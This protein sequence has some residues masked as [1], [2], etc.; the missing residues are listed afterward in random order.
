MPR[1]LFRFVLCLASLCAC[2]ARVAAA[3]APSPARPNVLVLF[4][5]DLRPEL[6]CY[7]QAHMRTPNID[8]L[9]ASGVRFDRAYTAQAVC[10]PSRV[11]FITGL[12]PDAT[13]VH[14]L[15]TRFRETI[16]DVVTLTQLFRSNG[17][18]TIGMGKVYHDEQPAEWNEWI[19]FPDAQEY[20]SDEVM[21]AI[22]KQREEARRLGLKGKELRQMAKGPAYEIA[23]DAAAGRLHDSLMTD[24]AV[25]EIRKRRA[26]PFFMAVGFKRPHLP[27]VA[28]RR[29]WDMY[30]AAD[31][32][33]PANYRLGAPTAPP[34]AL[35]DWGE[36]RAY[37]GIPGSGPVSDAQ[38]VD[39]IR[40]YR[41]SVSYADEQVGRILA[42]LRESGR[43]RDTIVVLWGD[44]GWKLGDHGAWCKH[45]N[46]ETDVRV[47][48]IVRAPGVSRPGASAAAV[49]TIDVYPT[50]CDLAGLD[51]PAR[52]EG[53]SLRPLLAGDTPG[54]WRQAARSQYK[55]SRKSGGDITGYTMVSGDHRY[56][57]WR[58]VLSGD[59]VAAELY[60]HRSDPAED[61]NL[62]QIPEH[63]ALRQRLA[64]E[65]AAARR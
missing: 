32:A 7:G 49:E 20:L 12:R 34:V 27:F 36:L 50:L 9:A 57:E 8:S 17:Y 55:R 58:N 18:H 65:L 53:R 62:A 2:R 23:P 39:L 10:L 1:N 54:D 24:R 52:L 11:S 37:L 41:A 31:T 4:M 59:L 45:T 3:D 64:A 16:P 61:R 63:A 56:T 13:G 28:P 46:F 14:D 30:P 29:F 33:S 35:V 38:A 21:E 19:T 15:K 42:A 48:L 40:G 25:E 44:H 47:P 43:D 26:E 5:D 22:G 60:D 6:G 51:A